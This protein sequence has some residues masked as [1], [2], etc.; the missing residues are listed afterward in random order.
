MVEWEGLAVLAAGMGAYWLPECAERF[1]RRRR[2]DTLVRAF[3]RRMRPTAERLF[4]AYARVG[5]IA[6]YAGLVWW[7]VQQPRS[8]PDKFAMVIFLSILFIVVLTDLM[9]WLIP[10]S[11]TL[12]GSLF[13]AIHSWFE[14]PDSF[15][16]LSLA[17]LGIYGVGYLVWRKTKG[18]GMGDVKLLAMAVWLLGLDLFFALWL[19]SWSAFL[20][21]VGR[22]LACGQWTGRSPLPYAP[23]LAAGMITALLFDGAVS[24]WLNGWGAGFSWFAEW[25]E[26]QV[27]SS[28]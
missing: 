4:F 9:A 15:G 22:S 26:I 19:S 12:G 1:L 16:W 25:P 18:I 14:R 24:H 2:E 7:V 6:L 21:V 27:L 20:T 10:N 17:S 23:H 11:L 13:F 5:I 28:L 8:L 3:Y